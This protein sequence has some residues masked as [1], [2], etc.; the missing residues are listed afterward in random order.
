M[1]SREKIEAALRELTRQ[2]LAGSNLNAL[3]K[4][5]DQ[6]EAAAISEADGIKDETQA[7][8]L[9]AAKLEHQFDLHP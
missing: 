7:K 4:A 6:K 5:A 2:S 9:E 8:L 1:I 3:Q